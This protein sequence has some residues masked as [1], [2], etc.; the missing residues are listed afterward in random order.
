MKIRIPR[1]DLMDPMLTHDDG[2]MCV[3]YEVPS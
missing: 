2:R 1:I 3:M